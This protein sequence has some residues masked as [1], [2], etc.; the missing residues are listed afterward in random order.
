MDII[1]IIAGESDVDQ[2]YIIQKLLGQITVDQNAAFMKNPRFNGYKFGNEMLRSPQA[3]EQK[4][5]SK[6]ADN[7]M[8]TEAL[9]FMRSCLR[10][11]PLNFIMITLQTH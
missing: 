2:L 8:Q 1:C 5:A 3:L 7:S 6:L 9:D 4:Y 11:D 10:Y